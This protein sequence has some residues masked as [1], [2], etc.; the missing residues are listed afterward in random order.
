MNAW[1]LALVLSADAPLRPVDINA[2]S[3][4]VVPRAR[5]AVFT[6]NVRA[7][8]DDYVLECDRLVADYDAA[9]RV[10]RLT[11]DGRVVVTRGD[12]VGRSD[13][14]VFDNVAER[15]EMTGKPMLSQG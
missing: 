4:A 3:L 7:T 5:Q 14:A 13:R 9:G 6:G 10:T 1:A 8:R 15:L 12:R 11:L 2:D